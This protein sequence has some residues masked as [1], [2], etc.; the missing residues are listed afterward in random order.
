MGSVPFQVFGFQPELNAKGGGRRLG[1]AGLQLIKGAEGE[2]R[3]V[4]VNP[5]CLRTGLSR[6]APWGEGRPCAMWF[7]V[8]LE[9]RGGTAAGRRCYVKGKS[10]LIQ[11]DQSWFNQ[12]KVGNRS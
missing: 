8:V 11:P 6:R 9:W 4:K 12:I 2:S 7:G 3:L 5:R 10:K 1:A